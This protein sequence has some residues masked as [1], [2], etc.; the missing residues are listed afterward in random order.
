MPSIPNDNAHNV[1]INYESKIQSSHEKEQQSGLTNTGRSVETIDE[2]NQKLSEKKDLN[3]TPITER[4][5]T[6]QEPKQTAID[7]KEI[8]SGN[9]AEQTELKAVTETSNIDQVTELKEFFKKAQD[10][11]LNFIDP[12]LDIGTRDL[13]HNI[14]SINF[15]IP[16]DKTSFILTFYPSSTI[17]LQDLIGN[18]DDPTCNIYNKIMTPLHHED[19]QH[20]ANIH[21]RIYPI[22]QHVHIKIDTKDM[23][24]NNFKEVL[25][26]MLAVAN[27]RTKDGQRMHDLVHF[28]ADNPTEPGVS[29]EDG[30]HADLGSSVDVF[31]FDGDENLDNVFYGPFRL[32]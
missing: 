19:S 26:E 15:H 27:I 16:E 20:E 13:D 31:D 21:K 14:I 17:G 22:D 4:A 11:T 25:I 29:F 1:S 3:T 10:F 2:I 30:A 5:I 8:Q 28:F 23:T 9:T 7:S 18:L 12:D 32:Q 24:M 6:L